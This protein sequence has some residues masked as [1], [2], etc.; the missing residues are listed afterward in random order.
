MVQDH[1]VPP[2]R[3]GTES[4]K[5]GGRG[6]SGPPP[7]PPTGPGP[8]LHTSTTHSL[9]PCPGGGTGVTP[10][11]SPEQEFGRT[12]TTDPSS[13]T[14]GTSVP[15]RA[16]P[17]GRPPPRGGL[18]GA[19]RNGTVIGP[20]GPAG[21]ATERPRSPTPATPS[22]GARRP[23]SRRPSG[24]PGV[25]TPTVPRVTTRVTPHTVRGQRGVPTP[26]SPATPATRTA[27][28]GRL[29]P[30]VRPTDFALTTDTPATGTSVGVGSGGLPDLDRG[31]RPVPVG[32][33][34]LPDRLPRR[35]HRRRRRAP[36]P[37]LHP[38]ASPPLPHPHLRLRVPTTTPH[39]PT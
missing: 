6:S 35:R 37:V 16:R 18:G 2:G 36:P 27:D 26:G 28:R 14:T 7:T 29:A 39:R 20:R 38:G 3:E 31:H 10:G 25:P 9:T 22:D 34:L 24:P 8:T 32:H 4:Q 17:G 5:R 12:H 30:S 11:D 21:T 19:G 15:T 33:P 23:C 1:V 13:R